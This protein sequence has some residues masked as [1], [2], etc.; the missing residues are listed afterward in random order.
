MTSGVP[1]GTVLGPILFIIYVNDIPNIV[2]S[3]VK[4]F[5]DDTKIYSELSHDSDTSVLQS[6]LDS[7]KE[8][9]RNWE[10]KINPD[11]CEVMRISYKQDKSN[12]Q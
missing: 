4:L 9:T 12:H 11:K 7:L 3:S 2:E 8:W 1:Q 5:A 10:V 6:D